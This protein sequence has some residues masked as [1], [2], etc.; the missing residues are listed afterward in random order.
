MLQTIATRD[1]KKDVK[2][3]NSSHDKENQTNRKTITSLEGGNRMWNSLSLSLSP[4]EGI[5][6]NKND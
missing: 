3:T 2:S 4:T 1:K 6:D 5:R